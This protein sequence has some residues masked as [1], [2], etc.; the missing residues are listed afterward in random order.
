[1]RRDTY[2]PVLAAGG[3]LAIFPPAALH[4]W[5]GQGVE[6]S[7]AFHFWAV[8]LSALV[9]TIA[10]FA[11]AVAGKRRHDARPALVGTAFTVMASLLVVHGLASPGVIAGMNGIGALTGAATIPAGG[12]I[13]ALAAFPGVRNHR[14]VDRIIWLQGALMAGV[15]ALGVL[16]LAFPGVVPRIPAPRSAAAWA[17]LVVG[18]AFYGLIGLRAWRTVKLARRAADVLVLVGIAWL[19]AALIPALTQ[20]YQALGWWVGHGLEVAGILLV[21]TPV[22]LDLLR[23]AP[24]RP[25]AGDLRGA[26]LVSAE[27]AFLGSQVRSLT[28]L[29]AEKDVYTEGHTRR[30]ALL[31]VRVGE[32]LG[33]P[34]ARLR[35][36]AIGG[37]LH[38]IGKLSVP[39]AILKKPGSLDDHEFEVVRR[40]PGWGHA[41]LG[42]LGFSP[43]IRRLVRDHH[44]RLDGAGYPCGVS[45]VDLQ[46]ETRVLTVCDVYDAL[47]S[48]RVYRDAW[49]H[50]RAL[51]LLRS[52]VGAAFDARC[53][54]ALERVLAE[55]GLEAPVAIAV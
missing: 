12:A 20:N 34:A 27:E 11:L 54:E 47:R 50:H 15:I 38:D 10:G 26:E 32:E 37:L 42:E 21:A 13:L 48:R 18:L 6:L 4:F 7:S 36:L 22:A 1:M 33:I 23:A 8:G 2:V 35:E 41:L 46:L 3:A 55:D 29:L 49:D 45:A 24:S 25:L 51:A 43:R 16:A 52:E 5:G 31:A 39:D 19:A 14:N 9:A 28:R 53:V 17:L 30:V 44:E 40:H